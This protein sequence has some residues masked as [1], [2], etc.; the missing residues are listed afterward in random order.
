MP[1]AFAQEQFAGTLNG[2]EVVRIGSGSLTRSL[3]SSVLLAF[4][5]V[6]RTATMQG[7]S[8]LRKSLLRAAD[9][10]ENSVS[11]STNLGKNLIVLD[12]QWNNVQIVN[13][14]PGGDFVVVEYAEGH[15]DLLGVRQGA[16]V[17]T[18]F[19]QGDFFVQLLLDA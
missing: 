18:L 9:N 4:D 17:Q 3:L 14:T 1:L 13:M 16:K 11:L 15:F 5:D 10:E 12:S 19:K 2:Y 6:Y 8:V 7:S